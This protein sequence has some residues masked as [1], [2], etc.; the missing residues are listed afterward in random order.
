MFKADKAADLSSGK[1]YAAKWTQ[2]GA[3]DSFKVSWILLGSSEWLTFRV[4][5]Y[6]YLRSVAKDKACKYC[7]RLMSAVCLEVA[8]CGQ[9]GTADACA[10]RLCCGF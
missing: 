2:D 1:L 4:L 6:I 5:V 10:D 3:A 8:G 7:N 9:P